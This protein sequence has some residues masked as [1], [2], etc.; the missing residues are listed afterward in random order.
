MTETGGVVASDEVK[1]DI[2]VELTMV[3]VA[4]PVAS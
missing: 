2:A 1:L 4:V 3:D